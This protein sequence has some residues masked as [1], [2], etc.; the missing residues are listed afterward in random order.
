MFGCMVEVG[1]FR[2]TL[3][4]GIMI[5]LIIFI[6]LIVILQ[7]IPDYFSNMILRNVAKQVFIYV[8]GTITIIVA[9]YYSMIVLRSDKNIVTEKIKNLGRNITRLTMK[10]LIEFLNTGLGSILL[11]FVV[12]VLLIVF[13]YIVSP[14]KQ[15][16]RFDLPDG[17]VWE[18]SKVVV[19]RWS[20][21]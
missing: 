16:C 18:C 13:Y 4:E 19:R 20:S 5:L 17:N 21:W 15:P 1:C 7:W 8:G 3:D 6:L 11:F 10:K 14:T 12:L 9:I 2:N